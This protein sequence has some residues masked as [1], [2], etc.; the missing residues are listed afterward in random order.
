[1]KKELTLFGFVVAVQ[2]A[3]G[4]GGIFSNSNQSAEYLRTF[5]RNSAVDNADIAYYNMAG[6]VDLDPG[7]TFN[8]SNQTIFQRAS[9]RTKGNPVLGDREWVSRN[10]A[11]L[12]P[13]LYAVHR[14]G[15]LALF[16][17]LETIGATAIRDWKEGL[18]TLDLL[19]KE[20]VGYGGAGGPLRAGDA[21]A[22]ALQAGLSPAQA[23]A[24]AV[25]AG[26]D[27]SP[28]PSRS[29]LKGS[30]ATLAWRHGAAFR[31]APWLALAAAGRLVVA[32]Q[33]LVGRVDAACTYNAQGHDLREQARILLDTTDRAVGYSGELGLNLNPGAGMVLS[34]TCEWATPLTFRTT[35]REG[36][37]GGGRV[38]DGA[39]ARL[40]LPRVLRLGLGWQLTPSLRASLGINQYQE[41][42]ADF[43]L[44]ANPRNHNDPKRDYGNTREAGV[45]LEYRISRPWLVSLGVNFNRIGQAQAATTD[46]SLPGAHADYLSLGAGFQV[47]PRAGL[48]L[49]VGLGHTRF[50]HRYEVADVQGDQRLQAAFAAQ[51]VAIQPRKEYDKRYLI[52]AFGLEVHCPR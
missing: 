13:N 40:D 6:T 29:T 39:R 3:L 2:A 42:S 25:A 46:L 45:A 33:D 43:S 20:Q 30:S 17:G 34:F 52:L 38:Q 41:A 31:V 16:T 35:V 44:L 24:A 47:Q 21:Y 19:G 32:R 28:Y 14:R 27:A 12:V 1:M 5:D 26:L 37:D 22:A 8:F 4:A 51:G 50:L 15:R 10:P 36:R 48:K 23:Q 11:W 18:P 49:N 9:V 7:W